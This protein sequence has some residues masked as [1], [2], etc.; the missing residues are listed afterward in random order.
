MAEELSDY[1]DIPFRDLDVKCPNHLD[2]TTAKISTFNIELTLE[3]PR[4]V[5]FK[6]MVPKSRE[7]LYECLLDHVCNSISFVDDWEGHIEHCRDG[8]EHMHA[9]LHCSTI[10]TYSPEG[11][12]MDVVRSYCMKLPPRTWTTLQKYHYSQRHHVFK[13]P[14][15]LAQHVETDDLKRNRVWCKYIRKENFSSDNIDATKTCNTEEDRIQE[16]GPKARLEC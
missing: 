16:T 4:N 11:A 14:A 6:R 1:F 8:Y 12:V 2:E 5:R 7:L 9:V 15:I 3:Y 13:C 10:G